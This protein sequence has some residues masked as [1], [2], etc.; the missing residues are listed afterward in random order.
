[1]YPL[2]IDTIEKIGGIVHKFDG[3]C[4]EIACVEGTTQDT[5]ALTMVESS[6]FDSYEKSEF[7]V[8]NVIIDS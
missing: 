7:G 8:T 5:E 6:L 1:M 3:K 4:G 2:C